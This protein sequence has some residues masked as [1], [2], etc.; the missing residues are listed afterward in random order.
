MCVCVYNI[1][2]LR[3]YFQS[4]GGG[5][6]GCCFL[7]QVTWARCGREMYHLPYIVQK[8]KKNNASLN[9]LD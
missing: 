6:A 9:G 7:V 4:G 5:G 8:R 2:G 1:Q 3:H